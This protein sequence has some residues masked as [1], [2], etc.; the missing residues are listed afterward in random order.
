MQH[1]LYNHTPF[2]AKK[3]GSLSIW[4]TQGMEKSHYMARTGYFKHTRHGGGKN[5][6][7]SLLELHQWTYRRLFHRAQLKEQLKSSE[8][9]RTIQQSK[10]EKRQKS[11]NESSARESHA[12]WRH[13]R[14]RIARRW[15]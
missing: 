2:F 4:S 12:L 13:S 9:I 15:A 7:N 3:Y 14:I 11:Y 10:K 8:L 6:A 5:R 1:I